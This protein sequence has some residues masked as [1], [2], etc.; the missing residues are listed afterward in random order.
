[1]L[2]TNLKSALAKTFT[3]IVICL[4]TFSFIS[5]AGGDKYEIYL[6][7]KLITQKYVGQSGVDVSSLQLDKTNSKDNLIIYYSHCGTVGKGRT[8][9]IKDEQNKV[10]KEWKFADA[11]GNDASMSI[12][13]KDILDLQ[14]NNVHAS[15]SLYYFSSQYLPKGR[16]LTAIKLK[17]KNVAFHQPRDGKYGLVV[18]AAML[19]LAAAGLMF[20]RE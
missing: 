11:T 9:L 19:G 8:I 18:T 3:F 13:V 7:D 1:M 6:N 20:R 17:E 15:L 16:M 4:T 14:K 12:P 5:K 2:H 10:L